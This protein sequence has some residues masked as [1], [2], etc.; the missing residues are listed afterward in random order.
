MKDFIKEFKRQEETIQ[1]IAKESET[2][3]EFIQI[4]EKI[5]N[6]ITNKEQIKTL[7][8]KSK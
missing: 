5:F 7:Y 8:W 1:T 3:E 4:I 6:K 2:F